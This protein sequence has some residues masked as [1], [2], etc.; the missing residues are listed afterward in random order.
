MQAKFQTVG[1]IP[2]SPTRNP[3]DTVSASYGGSDA[4]RTPTCWTL[5]QPAD[6]RDDAKGLSLGV[7]ARST[8]KGCDGLL[9]Q[10]GYEGAISGVLP[11]VCP[12]PFSYP[13]PINIPP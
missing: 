9:I 1:A 6:N 13:P 3:P 11:E 4:F 8:K 12:H 7:A 2:I 5:A 10:T